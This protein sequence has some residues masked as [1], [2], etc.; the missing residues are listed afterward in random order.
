L[1]FKRVCMLIHGKIVMGE[2]TSAE[3]RAGAS[4]NIECVPNIV[5]SHGTSSRNT[6]Q[7]DISSMLITNTT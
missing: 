3:I 5:A 6:G 2:E 4:R 7:T 1:L